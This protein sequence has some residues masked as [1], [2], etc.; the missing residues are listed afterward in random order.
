MV[1]A[2][3]VRGAGIDARTTQSPANRGASPHFAGGW[4]SPPADA[5][6]MRTMP[7]KSS[8][9]QR[10]RRFKPISLTSIRSLTCSGPRVR[11]KRQNQLP[12]ASTSCQSHRRLRGGTSVP[13]QTTQALQHS[14]RFAIVACFGHHPR[15]LFAMISVELS[16]AKARRPDILLHQEPGIAPQPGANSYPVNLR[17]KHLATELYNKSDVI[18]Q[19]GIQAE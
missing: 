13:K 3:L 7:K 2:P 1:W 11:Q 10:S 6:A 15:N 9:N 18:R 19:R 5:I 17:R 12:I 8:R 14:P 4:P 16:V